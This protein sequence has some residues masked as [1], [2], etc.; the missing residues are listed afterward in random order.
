MVPGT[1]EDPGIGQAWVAA[2]MQQA[3]ATSDRSV[4]LD[5]I[6]REGSVRAPGT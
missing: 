4:I 5:A 1:C 2:S 3:M 6:W